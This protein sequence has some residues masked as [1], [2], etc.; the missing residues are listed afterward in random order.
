VSDAQIE[1]LALLT[2]ARSL[3]PVRSSFALASLARARAYMKASTQ[4]SF[5]PASLQVAIFFSQEGTAAS[6]LSYAERFTA[7]IPYV[8]LNANSAEYL[9]NHS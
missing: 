5:E 1:R 7:S 3:V 8:F 4:P 2:G 9:R 6:I